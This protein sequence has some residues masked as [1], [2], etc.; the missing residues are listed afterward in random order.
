MR[1][2][3]ERPPNYAEIV[4]AL[5]FVGRKRGVYFCYGSAVYNPDRVAI[6]PQILE[7]ERV[8]SRRQANDP[9]SWWDRYIASAQFRFEEEVPAHIAE[10]KEFISYKPGRGARR[11]ML[12]A[13]AGRLA[14]P[15]YGG[16]IKIHDAKLLIAGR[17]EAEAA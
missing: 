10:W 8:H 4:A 5:P 1:I 15:L 9:K 6:P 13:I 7:H 3:Y 12:R 11:Q 14:G 17:I 2:L 16:L